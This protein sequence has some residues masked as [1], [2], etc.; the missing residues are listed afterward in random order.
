VKMNLTVYEKIAKAES[1]PAC[2]PLVE[3]VLHGAR[4]VDLGNGNEGVITF[5]SNGIRILATQEAMK[6]YTLWREF[7]LEVR[8][9][10]EEESA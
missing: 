1:H 8:P 7:V 9:V 2:P 3:A 5:E 4:R 6:P 10:D